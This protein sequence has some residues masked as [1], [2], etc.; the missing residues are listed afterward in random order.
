MI[1]TQMFQ[2]R[3]RFEWQQGKAGCASVNIE[4]SDLIKEHFGKEIPAKKVV[5]ILKIGP[6]V[7]LKFCLLTRQLLSNKGQEALTVTE[8]AKVVWVLNIQTD[9]VVFIQ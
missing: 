4:A 9:L 2:C 6:N 1:Q 3:T 8:D 7:I 5:S